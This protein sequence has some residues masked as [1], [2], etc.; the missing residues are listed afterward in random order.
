[1]TIHVMHLTGERRATCLLCNGR[2]DSDRWTCKRCH[3]R[4]MSAELAR[5]IDEALREARA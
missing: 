5:L 4:M 3:A 1:M 2:C